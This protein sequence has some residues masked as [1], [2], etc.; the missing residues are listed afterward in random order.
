MRHLITVLLVSGAV[1]FTPHQHI[2]SKY[3]IA[4]ARNAIS[5]RLASVATDQNQGEIDTEHTRLDYDAPTS[6]NLETNH[7]NLSE[8]EQFV[9]DMRELYSDLENGGGTIRREMSAVRFTYVAPAQQLITPEQNRQL[10]GAWRLQTPTIH[11]PDEDWTEMHRRIYEERIEIKTQ[12]EFPKPPPLLIYLPGLDGFGISATAQFDDLSSSFEFWRM[13]IDKGNL[14][15]SFSDLVQ[16]VVKFVKEATNPAQFTASPRDVLL[17]GESFGGLLTCA[18][19]MALTKI[20]SKKFRLRGM[21]LVNPAT[22]FDETDWERIV[23]FLTS[24]RHLESQ[25]EVTDASG[26]FRLDLPRGLPTP[27][28]IVGGL[29]LAAT[30]PDSKQYSNILD[31]LLEVTSKSSNE[32]T[33]AASSDGF[34]ILAE[35]LPAMVLQHRCLEWLPVG[36][37]VVNSPERLSKLDVPTLIIGGSDDNM[38]PTKE[39]TD[40]L[41]KLL[42]DCVKMEISG[43]G[44]FV[45]DNR[46]NL[47]EVL[48]DSHIDPFDIQKSYDPITDWALPPDHVVEAVIKKRVMP[49]RER[50]SPVFFSTDPISGKRRNGLSHVLKTATPL[51]IVGNHQLFGQDLGMVIS[52][53]LE[54]RCIM[55]RGLAHPIAV[56]GFAGGEA[57]FGN[58]PTVRK[59][60]RRWEFNEGSQVEGDLFNMFGAVKVSPRNFY[61]LLQNNQTVLLFPGGVKEALHGKGEEYQLFWPEKTDFVRVAAK[62]NATIVPL[63]A[64]GAADSADILLDAPE[65]LKLPFGIGDNLKNFSTSATAARYDDGNEDE[66][67]IPPL[68]LPKPFAARHYFL[69]GKSYDTSNLD[70]RNSDA[71]RDVYKAIEEEIKHDIGALLEARKDDPYAFDGIKRMTYQRLFRKEPPAFPLKSL[72]PSK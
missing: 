71:C 22:S 28:S 36:S 1:A 54:E 66:L 59:Q 49:L 15:V 18:V 44:H 63:S 27:Y 32:N 41:G 46:V 4:S 21:T 35:Y 3:K 24:L 47:T 11:G 62:F 30:V 50:A 53:L 48:L 57:N 16:S 2:I 12:Y 19:A 26:N 33:L 23:P 45:L 8:I 51:L 29:A 61:R 5:N 9:S 38:L 65:L 17:V 64:I 67:F 34:R 37:S 52:E 7:G 55:A 70:P 40:R 14:H 25:E 42:P 10:Y 43:A 39:E 58:E 72:S 68:A 56:D 31:F 60:R 69:F 6:A 13:S 20:Q